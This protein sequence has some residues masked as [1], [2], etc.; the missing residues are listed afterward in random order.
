MDM[1]L[2]FLDPDVHGQAWYGPSGRTAWKPLS[3]QIHLCRC[4]ETHAQFVHCVLPYI[5]D[6]RYTF[7]HSYKG[8]EGGEEF[9]CLSR[10]RWVGNL[11]VTSARFQISCHHG[12]YWI[13][14]VSSTQ[15]Y[16]IFLNQTEVC[17]T[18]RMTPG[19]MFTLGETCVEPYPPPPWWKFSLWN[20]FS[21][22]QR[23]NSPQN[24]LHKNVFR[25]QA[26][27]ISTTFD[28]SLFPR[29]EY[30][31]PDTT[32]PYGALENT[33]ILSKIFSF[34]ALPTLKNC[35]LVSS[36]WESEAVSWMKARSEI[37]FKFYTYREPAQNRPKLFLYRHEMLH[38]ANPNWHVDCRIE[39]EDEMF[40]KLSDDLDKVLENCH[41][42]RRL[43]CDYRPNI[44]NVLLIRLLNHVAG[45]LEELSVCFQDCQNARK[46]IAELFELVEFPRLK[47]FEIDMGPNGSSPIRPACYKNL[48]C[49]L[50]KLSS[51]VST[52]YVKSNNAPMNTHFLREIVSNREYPRLME[53]L[54]KKID[55][56]GMEVLRGLKASLVRLE[57]NGFSEECEIRQ[58]EE[59]VQ[60]QRESLEFLY[61][62]VPPDWEVVPVGEMPFLK[63]KDIL[64]GEG[65]CRPR[66]WGGKRSNCP[67]RQKVRSA[68][69]RPSVH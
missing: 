26:R 5:E 9:I 14:R 51:K 2:Q 27:S 43:N 10:I 45:S 21:T 49:S 29:I 41:V 60:R 13:R 50:I 67:G 16:A 55:W 69:R 48:T 33:L 11:D 58:V 42:I 12:N 15:D 65:E 64:F 61:L 44:D 56:D 19:D 32:E 4:T 46:D 7:G 17:Y 30:F 57:I 36:L 59:V 40:R 28:T 1:E 18:M 8:C 24:Y 25:F 47:R 35:R 52:L 20:V 34:L 31:P 37:R 66:I 62:E 53:A 22:E 63:R 54:I 6:Q 39:E 3:S 68:A 38:F 23:N